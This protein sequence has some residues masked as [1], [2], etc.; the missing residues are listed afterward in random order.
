MKL[1]SNKWLKTWNKKMKAAKSFLLLTTSFFFSSVALANPSEDFCQQ[2]LL[3][4]SHLQKIPK[5]SAWQNYGVLMRWELNRSSFVLPEFLGN[6]DHLPKVERKVPVH[7]QI[8]AVGDSETKASVREDFQKTYNLFQEFKTTLTKELIPIQ[9]QNS[10]LQV[11]SAARSN[12]AEPR[13]FDDFYHYFDQ[14]REVPFDLENQSIVSILQKN[15]DSQSSYLYDASLDQINHALQNPSSD[16]VV[17]V[18]HASEDGRLYD[19]H[20]NLIP[21]ST[22]KEMNKNI[23]ILA[24][25][26]CHS[27]AVLDRYELAKIAID[28]NLEIVLPQVNPKFKW[29]LGDGAPPVLFAH[30][31]KSVKKLDM[32]YFTGELTSNLPIEKKCSI[33][34]DLHHLQKGELGLFLNQKFLGLVSKSLNS[35]NYFCPSAG[36]RSIFTMQAMNLFNQAEFDIPLDEFS[37]ALSLP[38]A[39]ILF[40][41]SFSREGNYIGS[42]ATLVDD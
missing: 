7:A 4:K 31:L 13:S 32:T 30:F 27:E 20:W 37:A 33:T 23:K 35:L 41:N 18:L 5:Q 14:Y 6:T 21:N 10:C 3:N 26:S 12:E 22:F 39:K 19:A 34:I 25:Y 2:Y 42:K 15:E 1:K 38:S 24:I 29:L 16:T 36:V 17:L 8:L 11:V 40:K 9:D 28:E